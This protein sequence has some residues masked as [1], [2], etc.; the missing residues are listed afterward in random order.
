ME[1]WKE[2]CLDGCIDGWYF[3]WPLGCEEGCSRGWLD[4]FNVNCKEGVE[5][6]REVGYLDGWT[7]G[8][9]IGRVD[10]IEMGWKVGCFDGSF[11]IIFFLLPSSSCKEEDYGMLVPSEYSLSLWRRWLSHVHSSVIVQYW[12]TKTESLL[13]EMKDMPINDKCKV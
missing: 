6:G 10:G 12:W 9:L 13:S 4:G 11:K 8:C 7:L 2:G 3:G 1:S 5:L